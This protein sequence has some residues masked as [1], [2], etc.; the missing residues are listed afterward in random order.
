MSK[1]EKK[2]DESRIAKTPVKID[3][4]LDLELKRQ[5][6]QKVYTLSIELGI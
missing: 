4:K 5:H 3:N 6:E 1:K 2:L